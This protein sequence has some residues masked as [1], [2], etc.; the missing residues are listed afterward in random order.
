MGNKIDHAEV[1]R[2]AKQHRELYQWQV[3]QH[4][5]V[6]QSR[7]SHILRKANA[8]NSKRRGRAPK[9]KGKVSLVDHWEQVL[10][11]WGL[12]MGR[13][14]R[15]GNKRILYGYDPLLGTAA[16]ESVTQ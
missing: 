1:V 9:K 10:H 8:S 15:L 14:L 4:F 5:G 11:D 7:I 16:D 13:G 3:G 12:G 6:P 2:Y